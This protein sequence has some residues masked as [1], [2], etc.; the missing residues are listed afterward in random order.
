MEELING[1]WGERFRDLSWKGLG[2][3]E[4]ECTHLENFLEKTKD[5]LFKYAPIKHHQVKS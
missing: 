2:D 5:I 4:V 1:R 3:A